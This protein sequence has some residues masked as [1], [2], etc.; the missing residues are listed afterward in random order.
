VNFQG[1]IWASD[2][3]GEA[4][5]A[6]LKDGGGVLFSISISMT[7]STYRCILK[8]KGWVGLRPIS[9]PLLDLAEN[10]RDVY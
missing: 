10:L 6:V 2:I 3:R 9:L 1:W 8:P 4:K 5:T 7:H